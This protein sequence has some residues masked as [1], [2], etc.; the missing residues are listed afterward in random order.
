MLKDLRG[1]KKK[2]MANAKIFF[3]I[4]G[5]VFALAKCI[6]Y[7][8]LKIISLYIYLYN[9][10]EK[11]SLNKMKKVKNH[12]YSIPINLWVCMLSCHFGLLTR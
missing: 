8:K 6:Y 11:Y 4:M 5:G 12:L 2:K 3:K 9:D 1:N 7:F 10:Q